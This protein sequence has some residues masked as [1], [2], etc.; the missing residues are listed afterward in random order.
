MF[1]KKHKFC[2]LTLMDK[3]SQISNLDLEKK[4]DAASFYRS[5]FQNKLF[6]LLWMQKIHW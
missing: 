3:L 5:I 2:N 1:I 6:K 4:K